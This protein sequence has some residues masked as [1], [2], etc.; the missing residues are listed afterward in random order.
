[1][2]KTT[3]L[4]LIILFLVSSCGEK[5]APQ[6]PANQ[7]LEKTEVYGSGQIARRYQEMAG[8]KE[9]LMRDYF[10]DGRTKA[11]RWFKADK[12]V[13]RTVLYY[14]GGQ[15]R[16]VQYYQD[17]KK[18]GGDTLFYENGSIEF[19]VDFHEEKKNGYLRKWS[20]EGEL[21]F[22]AKYAMDSLVE[23]RGKSVR[24]SQ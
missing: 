6:K 17:G 10:L 21:V 7:P 24:Q 3:A 4:A 18:E 20:L 22:E 1:M 14:P 23:V 12:Q 13:G 15:I 2:Y 8:K 11:E 9:G 5:P 19:A 16:E